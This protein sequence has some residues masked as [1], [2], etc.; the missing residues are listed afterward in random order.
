MEVIARRLQ[1]IVEEY[2]AGSA[3]NPDW[4]SAIVITNHRGPDE[5]IAPSLRSWAAK[6]NKAETELAQTRAKIRE[7]RRLAVVDEAAAAA[8]ADGVLPAGSKEKAKVKSG[9][10]RGLAA[11]DGQ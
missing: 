1:A 10:G 4:H 9:R 2:A 11:P 3:G 7:H 6:R 5:A 8:V